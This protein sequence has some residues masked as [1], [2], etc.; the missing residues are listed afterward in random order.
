MVAIPHTG[1]NKS[2]AYMHLEQ[3]G[4]DRLA[5]M[6]VERLSGGEKQRVAVARSL[7]RGP[8]VVLA[9]EPTGSLDEATEERI[10]DLF[11][12]L[13]QQGVRFVIATHSSVVAQACSRRV[14]I[15]DAKL[16]D[17]ASLPPSATGR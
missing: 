1:S 10:L 5:R 16:V 4:L 12:E 13:Q 6:R 17:E 2:K 15:I 14:Q 7:I 3:V 11:L 8:R 9:D